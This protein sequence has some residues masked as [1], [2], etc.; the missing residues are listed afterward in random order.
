MNYTARPPY[1]V[2]RSQQMQRVAQRREKAHKGNGSVMCVYGESG[3]GKSIFCEQLLQD[4]Q[5][6]GALDAVYVECPPPIGSVNLGA[7][8]P[9]Q[10]FAHVLEQ[11]LE[12][13]TVTAKKKLAMNIGLTMLG[14]IPFVG[15]AF[16]ATKEVMRDVREFKRDS[17]KVRKT[18]EQKNDA[19]DE[20]F[21]ALN[22]YVQ[23]RTL[24]IIL[25]D[26][27]WMDA[28][29]VEMV[30]K[31]LG[32]IDSMRILLILSMQRST[33][34]AK[35]PA[36]AAWIQQYKN[37][38]RIEDI[39]LPS[40]SSN[41]IS[42]C[43]T[44][45]L[46][47]Y[48]GNRILEEWLLH[49][50]AG[51]PSTVCEYLNYFS[52]NPP[53][54]SD[55]T[56]DAELLDSNLVPASLQAAFSKNVEQLSEDDRTLLS[57]CSAEGREFTV[58]VIAHLL[59]TDTLTAIKRLKSLQHRTGIVRSVGPHA[60]YGVKSTMYEFTQA[61]HY[62]YFHS[63]LEYEEKTELHNRITKLLQ[64]QYNDS[65]DEGTR[66]QIAPYIVAHSIESGD[67]DTARAMLLEAA[68]AA[69]QTGSKDIVEESYRL[70]SMLPPQVETQRFQQEETAFEELRNRFREH[71]DDSTDTLEQPAI[72]TSEIDRPD[73]GV[74]R[75]DAM[76]YFFSGDYD[77][78]LERIGSFL[79]SSA[80]YI[81]PSDYALLLAMSSRIATEGNL[82][83]EAQRYAAEAQTILSDSPNPYS[84]CYLLNA[85]GVLS[86]R[87]RNPQQAWLY[88]QRAAQ[89]SADLSD[90][91]K[92]LTLTNITMLLRESNPK[93]A[94]KFER[95]AKQLC[96]SLHF[97]S[98][99]ETV[100]YGKVVE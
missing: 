40:F 15:A 45:F 65:V 14:M 69:E 90:D 10:P 57:L 17:K 34:E 21:H 93:Q 1:L 25:D 84:M 49:R 51:I 6:I 62:T 53:F 99:M 11:L 29:S 89:S 35:N 12:K 100:F 59:N 33:A 50:S 95:A 42:E 78:A 68:E 13:S 2:A 71:A 63:T 94:R 32:T 7:I 82:F 80:Q 19:V 70:F 66:R 23:E 67:T 60:R 4:A 91:L 41:D 22:Q 96:H 31:L 5:S 48:T 18:N 16:D 61:L 72:E 97:T 58:F 30:E 87:E 38:D 44:M 88:F 39:D 73:V 52:R 98:V 77:S 37:D 46:P 56:L 79:E 9:M 47:S 75:D 83:S 36:L 74:V 20:C 24:V 8:Q 54:K 86:M 76:E 55:G 27:Q 64:K 43:C 28:Q 81:E 3:Y 26:A 85:L 92:L